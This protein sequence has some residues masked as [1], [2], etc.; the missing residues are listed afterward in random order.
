M[1]NSK[2][3]TS[4]P[5]NKEAE[6]TKSHQ[7][8]KLPGSDSAS[9]SDVLKPVAVSVSQPETVSDTNN[10][11]EL[12]NKPAWLDEL[13]GEL[14]QDQNKSFKNAILIIIITAIA[15][16]VI[17]YIVSSHVEVT[18]S[19]RDYKN[20]VNLEKVRTDSGVQA[21]KKKTQELSTLNAY[22]DLEKTFLTYQSKVAVLRIEI[23]R[24]AGAATDSQIKQFSVDLEELAM[25]QKKLS[26]IINL[27]SIDEETRKAVIRLTDR[28]KFEEL[29]Q[30]PQ[31]GK[32][33]FPLENEYDQVLSLI[34]TK[35]KVVN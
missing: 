31:L 24:M 21:E 13:V 32:E 34:G 20:N 2:D 26:D 10:L 15:N 1:S 30:N 17:T 33:I 29:D 6:G 4:V 3:K 35:M 27:S 8:V 22:N 9:Q 23:E 12:E 5:E 25:V 28:M 19:E 7:K 14:K 16:G 18:K 11:G